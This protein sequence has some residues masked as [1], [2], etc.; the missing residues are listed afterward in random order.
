[1]DIFQ[2]F[3][4]NSKSKQWFTFS[5]LQEHNRQLVTNDKIEVDLLKVW[6]EPSD[7]NQDDLDKLRFHWNVT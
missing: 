3:S 5:H 6:I 7:F 2:G 4:I 1:M